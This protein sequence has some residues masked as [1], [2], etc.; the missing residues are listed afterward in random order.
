MAWRG[1]AFCRACCFLC[2]R[3]G[4]GCAP[5]VS[6]AADPK[7]L[8]QLYPC[9]DTMVIIVDD[10]CDATR[11]DS[12]ASAHLC[13]A[14]L[15]LLFLPSNFYETASYSYSCRTGAPAA[16]VFLAHMYCYSRCSMLHVIHM[17]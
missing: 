17:Y 5:R 6:S 4:H 2:R 16:R 14:A 10:R 11:L 12:T 3:Y 9:P 1:V 13:T 7:D 8:G 15:G